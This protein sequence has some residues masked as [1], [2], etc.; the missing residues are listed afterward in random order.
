MRQARQ[1]TH[2]IYSQ[3]SLNGL[4]NLINEKKQA[5]RNNNKKGN[6]NG[7]LFRFRLPP[8]FYCFNLPKR[9][10]TFTVVVE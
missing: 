9:A 1:K 3:A 7:C 2:L 4:R 10:V 6:S 5:K 8:L